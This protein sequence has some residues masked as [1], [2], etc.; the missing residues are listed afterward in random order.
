MV[1]RFYVYI[2]QG[3]SL[4]ICDGFITF[5]IWRNSLLRHR[6][7]VILIQVFDTFRLSGPQ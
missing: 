2:I 7:M 6:Y 3:L 4:M 1:T 5:I